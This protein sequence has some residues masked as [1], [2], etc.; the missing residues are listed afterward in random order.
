MKG[1][2][3]LSQMFQYEVWSPFVP[4]KLCTVDDFIDSDFHTK[5]GKLN[6][7]IILLGAS[8]VYS[9]YTVYICDIQF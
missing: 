2:N 6:G 7:K 3:Q 1:Q 4:E 8:T 5:K 9:V